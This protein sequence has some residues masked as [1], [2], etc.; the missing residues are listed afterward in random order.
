M[1]DCKNT[2][3]SSGREQRRQLSLELVTLTQEFKRRI[4]GLDGKCADDKN[5]VAA[6]R[7]HSSSTAPGDRCTRVSDG[8]RNGHAVDMV[9][10]IRRRRSVGAVELNTVALSVK[11]PEYFPPIRQVRR[12]SICGVIPVTQVTPGSPGKQ[13]LEGLLDLKKRGQSSQFMRPAGSTENV[14][15]EE[16]KF[17][18]LRNKVKARRNSAPKCVEPNAITRL[19]KHSAEMERISVDM[20]AKQTNPSKLPVR[21]F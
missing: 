17:S 4:N 15:R 8:V 20:A 1:G 12:A 18:S 2:I 10:K 19:L 7:K 14:A 9:V 13:S 5:S 21:W 16:C 3:T 11:T 6:S